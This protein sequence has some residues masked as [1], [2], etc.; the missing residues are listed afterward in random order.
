L[1]GAMSIIFSSN[2]LPLS[3]SEFGAISRLVRGQ[4]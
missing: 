2:T 3:I 4:A 1:S